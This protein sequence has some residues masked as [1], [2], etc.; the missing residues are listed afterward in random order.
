MDGTVPDDRWLMAWTTRAK[1]MDA[2]NV[3][4]FNGLPGTNNHCIIREL[5]NQVVEERQVV[6]IVVVAVEPV[7]RR[8]CT[9]YEGILVNTSHVRVMLLYLAHAAC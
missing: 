3:T 2:L 4:T 7:R 8:H 9:G 6:V 5:G 1:Y